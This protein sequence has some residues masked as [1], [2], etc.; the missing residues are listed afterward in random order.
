M[1]RE[2]AIV[3]QST[4]RVDALD[5]VTGRYVYGVDTALPGMLWGKIRRSEVPHGLIIRIDVSR[6]A[7]LP[8]VARWTLPQM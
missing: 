5:K 4:V 2:F 1:A 7:A 8:G 6:A 3:G